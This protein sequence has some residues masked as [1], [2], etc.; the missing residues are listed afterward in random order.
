MGISRQAALVVIATFFTTAA[1]LS[2]KL[3]AGQGG[4]LLGP[5]PLNAAVVLGFISYAA[6]ALLFLFALRGGELSLLYPLWSL[7]FVWIFI[8]S[9][10]VLGESINAFNWLGIALIITGVSFVGRGAKHA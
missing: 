3:G 1:Q 6:A 4:F 7:S 8:V 10:F 5:L 2:F 9:L